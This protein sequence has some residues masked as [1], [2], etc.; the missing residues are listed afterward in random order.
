[1]LKKKLRLNFTDKR[2]KLTREEV[3]TSSMS[4]SLLL[5][6][7]P[8]WHCQYHHIFLTILEKKE[9]DTSFIIDLLR[10]RKR[11]IA[12]PKISENLQ[13]EHFILTEGTRL[14]ENSWGIPEPETGERID[15]ESIDVVYIPLL[16]FDLSGN[17]VGYGKGRPILGGLQK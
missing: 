2:E 9:V 3:L 7:L 12:V 10:N 8:I 11:T 4:I 15:P 13:L 5:E 17:R 14:V 1:M 16:A 6:Q